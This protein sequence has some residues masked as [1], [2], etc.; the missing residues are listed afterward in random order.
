MQAEHAGR[1][2]RENESAQKTVSR[3]DKYYKVEKERKKDIDRKRNR[4]YY[5]T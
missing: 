4:V 2:D 5:L 1:S 3:F